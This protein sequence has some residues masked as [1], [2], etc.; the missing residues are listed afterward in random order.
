[1]SEKF[2][3]IAG[4]CSIENEKV[5][6]EVCES[7]VR[8]LENYPQ[9]DYIFKSSYLK[10]NRTS[11]SSFEG[12]SFDESM[13]ILTKVRE[14]YQVKVIT[15]VHESSD[16]KELVPYVDMLQ[17]PAFLFRQTKLIKTAAEAKPLNIKKGQFASAEDMKHAL[18][19]AKSVGQ[20]T[21]FLCERGNVFGYDQ[22]VLDFLNIPRMKKFGAPVILDATHSTQFKLPTGVS[23]GAREFVERICLAGVSFNCSGLFI[24]VHSA[25]ENA[26]SDQMS[27][28][29][30]KNFEQ[31][32]DKCMNVKA[33]LETYVP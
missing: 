19:K 25:I 12:L 8:T 23:G 18:Q 2:I 32:I 30:L 3:I 6:M 10:A 28:L 17:I 9:I 16:V 15:D 7:I 1:M 22:L 29:E 33:L 14:T 31:L 11:N 27:Q 13:R 5:P 24:E 4:P 21:V 20:E 26:K